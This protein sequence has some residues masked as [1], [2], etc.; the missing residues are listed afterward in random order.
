VQTK[1]RSSKL[2]SIKIFGIGIGLAALILQSSA[3]KIVQTKNAQASLAFFLIALFI[4][5]P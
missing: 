3:L 5:E 4:R 1:K 2:K